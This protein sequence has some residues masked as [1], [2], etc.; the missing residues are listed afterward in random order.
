MH[1][2]DYNMQAYLLK[3]H[4]SVVIVSFKST[5]MLIYISYVLFS[6]RINIVNKYSLIVDQTRNR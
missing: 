2:S 4:K 5:H 3:R 1:K 6:S